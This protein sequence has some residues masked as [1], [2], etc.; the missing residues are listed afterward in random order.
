[1]KTI[2][3]LLN[4]IRHWYSRLYVDFPEGYGD[5]FTPEVEKFLVDM[6]DKQGVSVPVNENSEYEHKKNR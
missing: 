3:K 6:K 2:K 5:P 1:M 4:R